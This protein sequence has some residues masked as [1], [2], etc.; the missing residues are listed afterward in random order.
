MNQT[1]DINR[2]SA[3]LKLNIRLNQKPFLLSIAG[4][5]GFVFVISFFVAYFSPHALTGMHTFF[6]FTLLY[7]GVA[8]MAGQSYSHLNT[9]EKSIASISLPA[10]TFEKYFVPWILSS[11]IWAIVAIASYLMFAMLINGFWSVAF[12][13]SYQAFNP[14]EIQL[15]PENSEFLY[16]GYFLIHSIFFLGATAFQKYSIPKTLLASFIIQNAVGVVLALFGIFLFG[17]YGQL[18]VD[19]NSP[20]NWQ[21]EFEYFF[22]EFLPRLVK[23]TFAYAIPIILYVAAFFKLKEREV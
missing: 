5:F 9:T 10:S 11:I 6:Y 2:T 14:F 21:P 12:G 19:M 4:F 23:I 20:E 15:G 18:N 17:G 13:F 1:F 8:L 7:G 22:T 3:L 16:K